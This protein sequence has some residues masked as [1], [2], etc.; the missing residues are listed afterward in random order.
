MH[1]AFIWQR[2]LPYHSA[3]IRRVKSILSGQGHRVTAIEIAS[4]DLSY[5]FIPTDLGRDYDSVCC[6]PH[7]NYHDLSPKEI[8][9]RV[10]AELLSLRPDV[11][12]APATAFPEGMGALMYRLRNGSISIVMDDA[13]ELSDRRGSLTRAAKRIIHRNADAAFVPALSHR[14]Y[15]R[16]LGF[17]AERIFFGVDVVDNEYFAVQA[18]RARQQGARIRQEMGLPEHYFLYVG[19]FLPR[20]GLDTL[21]LAYQLY[22]KR[23]MTAPWD[24]ILIGEGGLLETLCRNHHKITG[25]HVAGGRFGEELCKFY[26]LA[27]ALVVPSDIDPWGLVVN[28]GLASGLPVLV[29]RGCGS[30]KTLVIDSENGWSFRPGSVEDLAVLLHRLSLLSPATRSGMG[31]RSREMISKWSLDRFAS[32]VQDAIDVPRRPAAGLL[33]NMMTRLW[34]GRNS[35]T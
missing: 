19:R 9:A 32:A 16:N 27:E 7:R 35:V 3:R 34:T 31:M 13:W 18:D 23:T 4:R 22:R 14:E 1:I 26:G 6:F 8:R 29:S 21:L 15:Y 10:V 33:S 24:L 12:F 5:R 30:A 17:P 25:L 28:E 2:F 11:V 20:K